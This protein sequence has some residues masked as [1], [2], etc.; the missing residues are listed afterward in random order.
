MSSPV[1]LWFRDDLRLAD[2]PALEAALASGQPVVGLYILD[3][4][5]PDLRPLG[6]AARW[7]LHHALADLAAALERRGT[8]L[9][10]RRGAATEVVGSLLGEMSFSAVLWNRRYEAAAITVD[11][12]VKTMVRAA[13]LRADSFNAS[14]LYE[15]WAVRS[16][17]GDPMKV[18]SPF[19]RAALASGEPP[20]P[21]ASAASRAP[22]APAGHFDALASLPL[23]ALGLLPAT[24][25]WAGGLRETWRPGE[26]GAQERLAAFLDDEL[27]G[28]ADGRD[29]PDMPSTSRLSPWLRFGNIG[30]RQIWHAA[31]SAVE[32]GAASHRDLAKFHAELGWREFSYHLL[33]AFPDLARSN[34]QAKFDAF[35]WRD[36]PP[37]L[38]AWQRGRTGY[39]LVDA[40]LRQLWHTGWMH[41]R[42]RMVVASFLIKHLLLDWRSGEEWFWD[43]LVD[44]DPASNAAS[45]QWVAGSGA[46]AAP[47]YRIF[48][49][50]L[51]GEKFDP[52]G[53]Y[54]RRWVPELA[55]MPAD[56]IHQPWSASPAR[57]SAAGVRLGETY[58]RPIV[59]HDAARNRALAALELTKPSAS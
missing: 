26:D 22:L 4:E 12:A 9:L 24:P 18:F 36:D 50:I 10:L 39:P 23:V 16:K 58:P 13:G 5:S 8:R 11:T 33:H 42:V 35:P 43:T 53:D 54:V 32:Q 28:Y 37:A 29:R 49:P 25:D 46:D 56:V 1:L 31:A 47:Y 57:L 6:G 44:A 59:D 15:P 27:K 40:G 21:V 20:S 2:N 34:F 55:G 19:W 41:N 48:N 38:A 30:P 51:Q 7:W 45:W 52:Q 17:A 14:L 3:E